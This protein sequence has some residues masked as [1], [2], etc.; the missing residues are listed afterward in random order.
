MILPV[1]QKLKKK[2]AW[3]RVK[4]KNNT[5]IKHY[6]SSGKLIHLTHSPGLTPNRR[7][8]IYPK[9][10]LYFKKKK[11]KGRKTSCPF[12]RTDHLVHW[13]ALS[14]KVIYRKNFLYLPKNYNWM[15]SFSHPPEKNNFYPK[16]KFI[17]NSVKK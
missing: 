15:K 14:K 13:P 17:E 11:F 8:K 16:K 6:K 5:V 1:F 12:E 7:K 10:L 9:N 4:K 2:L 3:Y